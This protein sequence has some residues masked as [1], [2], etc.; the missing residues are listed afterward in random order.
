MGQY[1]P[2][3]MD[4]FGRPEDVAVDS[5]GNVYVVDT[6]TIASRSSPVMAIYLTQW[7]SEGSGRTS[8]IAVDGTAMS[9]WWISEHRIQKFTSDGTY[10]TQWGSGSG[11]GQLL[12]QRHRRRWKR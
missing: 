8:G 4:S 9:M 5:N 2:V 12:V 7:G 6:S 1:G 3:T 10:L 11:D